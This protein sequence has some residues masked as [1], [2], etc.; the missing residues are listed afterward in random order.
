MATAGEKEQMFKN[1]LEQGVVMLQFDARRPGVSVPSHLQSDMELRLNFNHRK[2]KGD[3]V[4]NA[5]GVRETLSFGGRWTPVSVP[6]EAVYLLT[7]QGADT[8]VYPEDLP[9]EIVQA[10]LAQMQLQGYS[11]EALEENR[12][13]PLWSARAGAG[14]GAQAPTSAPSLAV[15][16]SVAPAST[17]TA[18][19]SDATEPKA[20]PATEEPP[21][22][23]STRTTPTT[24]T[25]APEV[26]RPHL[27]LVK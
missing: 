7:V 16:P 15:V 6:W 27:R 4:V 20:S 12:P 9:E 3:L 22:D 21:S 24:P 25:S 18:S 26:K 13:R 1:L 5:W 10:A 19:S 2:G 23:A 17:S 11:L 8:I 14:A